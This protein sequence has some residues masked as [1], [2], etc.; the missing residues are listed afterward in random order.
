MSH[1]DFSHPT[2][3]WPARDGWPADGEWPA[4]DESPA[5]DGDSARDAWPAPEGWSPDNQ[6]SSTGAWPPGAG[7]SADE[8]R[9]DDGWDDDEGTA[10]YPLTYERDDYATAGPQPAAPPVED[11][12]E[13]WPPVSRPEGLNVSD[14]RGLPADYPTEQ[15]RATRRS[16]TAW[17]GRP[18]ARAPRAAWGPAAPPGR[19]ARRRPRQDKARQHGAHQHRARE[20][21]AVRRPARRRPLPRARR[22][23]RRPP[24]RSR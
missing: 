16:E 9:P 8:D 10:P 3:A 14:Q 7:T 15:A 6:R 2:D 23:Q 13:P 21:R 4:H 24:D 11:S 19:P 12:W 17:R 20:H 1:W 22:R 18:D 5:A